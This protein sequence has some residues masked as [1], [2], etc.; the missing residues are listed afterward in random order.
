MSDNLEKDNDRENERD[1][2]IGDCILEPIVQIINDDDYMQEMQEER[3]DEE[4]SLHSLEKKLKNIPPTRAPS[5]HSKVQPGGAGSIEVAFSRAQTTYAKL[6]GKEY[7]DILNNLINWVI[8]D[9]QPF[10]VVDNLHFKKFITSLNPRFQIFSRQTLRKKIGEKYGQ[11]KKDIIKLF[12]E[13]D[14]KISFTSDMWTS[15]TGAPYMVL[16]AHWIDD[17]WDLKHTVIAFQRFPHPHTGE[18]IKEATLKIFQEFSITTKA[19]TITIDNGANQ[20]AGMNLLS[21]NLS[22][23]LQ[24]NFNIIRCGAHTVALV[25]NAGL[26]KL[27]PVIDKKLIRDVRTRWNSTYSMLESFLTNKLIITSVLSLNKDFVKLDLSE[28]E[29]KEIEHFCSFLKPFFDFTEV[30]SG[31][32]YPTLRTLLLLLDHLSDHITT[33]IYKTK[34]KWVKEVAQEMNDKFNSISGNLYNTSAYLALKEIKENL[35]DF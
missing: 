15:D 30:M 17:K 11:Y 34:I 12:Q 23:E 33:T 8:A 31:S 4:V 1:L 5:T 24:V 10:R 22:S 25:V 32:N 3:T 7:L 20:V 13:N 2:T 9:C 35:L 6:Q 28:S 19:S 18:Q 16:T 26:K 27:Q 29:W 14:S 21:T